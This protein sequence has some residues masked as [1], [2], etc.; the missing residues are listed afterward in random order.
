MY[1]QADTFSDDE[2]PSKGRLGLGARSARD[3]CKPMISLCF[4]PMEGSFG[5][6]VDLQRCWDKY[7]LPTIM[8]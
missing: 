8:F 6:F 7:F 1:I 3:C 2:L 4:F 5:A